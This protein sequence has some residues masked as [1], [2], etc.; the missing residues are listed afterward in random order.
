MTEK[1]TLVN[2]SDNNQGSPRNTKSTDFQVSHADEI[3]DRRYEFG[4]QCGDSK[5]EYEAL[6]KVGPKVRGEQNAIKGE[7]NYDVAAQHEAAKESYPPKVP[8]SEGK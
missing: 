5:S 2:H 8:K 7:R 4:G 6:L 3:H 1:N